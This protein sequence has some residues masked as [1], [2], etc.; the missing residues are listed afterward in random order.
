MRRWNL[1]GLLM[2]VMSVGA[3][4][5]RA[6]SFYVGTCKAG[7][8]A[9]LSAAIS[10][11]PAGSTIYVCPGTYAEQL[12]ISKPLTLQGVIS[13]NT[14]RAIIAVPAGLQTFSSIVFSPL[15]PQVEV[16][17]GPVKLTGLIVDGTATSNC[18]T[19]HFVGIH[20]NSGSSGEV[21][22]VEVRNHTCFGSPVSGPDVAIIAE[23][24]TG[25]MQTVTIENSYIH[26][27]VFGGI[28]SCTDQTPPTLSADLRG[29]YIVT[30]KY[31]IAQICN[32]TGTIKGNFVEG[33]LYGI[34]VQGLSTIS[35]NTV[36][37]AAYAITTQAAS[38]VL[39]NTVNNALIGISYSASGASVLE[40]KIVNSQQGI[41]VG[42]AGGV[43]RRNLI[44]DT[45]MGIEFNCNTGTIA[46]NTITS[47]MTAFDHAPGTFSG[48]NN[49]FNVATVRTGC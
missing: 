33:E 9:K 46:G 18:P 23:N 12:I 16:T 41:S 36:N 6:T 13:S 10:A 29:N 14:S 22:G 39:R 11:A 24:S 15:A 31:G 8:F 32:T 45:A 30:A 21:N 25:G 4:P 28:I 43:V 49:T 17:A 26:D 37:D 44:T 35:G 1:V 34:F 7:S 47:A 2:V 42:A 38:A 20:Y 27:P 48:S 5:L 19:V 40:N 3:Y